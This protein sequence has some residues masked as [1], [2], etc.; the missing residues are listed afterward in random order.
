MMHIPMGS[1]QYTFLKT[2]LPGNNAVELR[3]YQMALEPQ[4]IKQTVCLIV[5]ILSLNEHRLWKHVLG[6]PECHIA[7]LENTR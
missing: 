7:V 5:N 3:S 4:Q 2:L 1:F 6:M